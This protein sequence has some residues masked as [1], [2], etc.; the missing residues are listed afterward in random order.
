[1]QIQKGGYRLFDEEIDMQPGLKKS[2]RVRLE[3]G[4]S[5]PPA[6]KPDGKSRGEKDE[7]SRPQQKKY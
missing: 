7:A 2:L 5:E 1:V 6:A 4:E 3:P